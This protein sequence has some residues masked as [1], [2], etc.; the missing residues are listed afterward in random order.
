MEGADLKHSPA[1]AFIIESLS[2]LE[3][4]AFFSNHTSK[5]WTSLL[6]GVCIKRKN[7]CEQVSNSAPA[8][9]GL[10]LPFNLPMAYIPRPRVIPIHSNKTLRA[11][12]ADGQ[13]PSVSARNEYCRMRTTIHEERETTSC[14]VR[15]AFTQSIEHPRKRMCTNS[16][17]TVSVH[18]A[19]PTV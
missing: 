5:C 4:S 3:L 12:V 13:Q 19:S 10:G 8:L 9:C 18:P 6:G 2:C 7:L 11:G 1:H 15:V 17:R 16:P 14:E